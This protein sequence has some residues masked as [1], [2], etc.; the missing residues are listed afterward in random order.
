MHSRG[1]Y[2]QCGKTKTITEK[3]REI[4]SVLL[5]TYLVKPLFSRNFCQKKSVVRNLRNFHTVHHD[6]PEI[7][8]IFL[9]HLRCRKICQLVHHGNVLFLGKSVRL[10]KFLNLN[11]IL[12]S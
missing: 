1:S 5:S 9:R 2:P 7:C 11:L 10:R 6:S 8:K 3:L 4:N 12:D